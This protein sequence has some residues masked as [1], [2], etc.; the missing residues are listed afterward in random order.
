MAG[1]RRSSAV[2]VRG[3]QMANARFPKFVLLLSSTFSRTPE[4]HRHS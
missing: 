2:Q 3:D 1:F 4:S